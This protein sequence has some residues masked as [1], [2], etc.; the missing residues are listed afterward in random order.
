[1]L[2]MKQLSEIE[3]RQILSLLQNG[4]YQKKIAS[5]FYVN[6]S[7]ISRIQKKYKQ[8][9]IIKHVGGI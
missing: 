9:G 4:F 5:K 2:S 8:K 7:T 1:M 6:Q 3:V